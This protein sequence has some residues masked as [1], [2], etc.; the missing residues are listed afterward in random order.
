MPKYCVGDRIFRTKGDAT[1]EIRRVLHGSKLEAPLA[2]EDGQLIRDLFALHPHSDRIAKS[3]G[4]VL[5]FFV[6]EH[7]YEGTMT[8]GFYA[9]HAREVTSF[10]YMTCLN[11][12]RAKPDSLTAMRR[13]IMAGQRD[14]LRAHF[15]FSAT[16]RCS[17]C[18]ELIGK[19]KT[20]TFTM[21]NRSSA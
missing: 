17:Y 10:S 19:K 15:L 2:G 14:I 6:R 9:K 3:L 16:A 1:K 21:R 4:I 7:S 5:H 12:S 20:R 8:R 13:M 18:K 11:P